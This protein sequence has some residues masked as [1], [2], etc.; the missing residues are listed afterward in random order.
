[1]AGALLISKLLQFFMDKPLTNAAAVSKLIKELQPR[2]R[3]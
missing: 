1:M 3:I 2:C